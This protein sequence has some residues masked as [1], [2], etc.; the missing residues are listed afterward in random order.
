[1]PNEEPTPEKVALV[2]AE[3]A[4]LLADPRYGKPDGADL[5]RKVNKIYQ[6]AYGSG[7]VEVSEGIEIKTPFPHPTPAPGPEA[8]ESPQPLEGETAEAASERVEAM[9]TLRAE[10]GPDFQQNWELTRSTVAELSR[11]REG[12]VAKIAGAAG[13]NAEMMRMVFDIAKRIRKY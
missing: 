11:G 3:V 13:N 7:K 12:L 10:W 8:L 2:R 4:P 6:D 5:Q 9:K 1:M